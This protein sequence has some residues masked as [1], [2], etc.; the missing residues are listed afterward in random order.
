MKYVLA[1]IESAFCVVASYIAIGLALFAQGAN[2]TV[3][4][5]M[6]SRTTASAGRLD[7]SLAFQPIGGLVLFVLLTALFVTLHSRRS[8]RRT[9]VG[10]GGPLV[11]GGSPR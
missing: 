10:A 2:T 6:T 4:G 9:L 3:P 7:T 11:A 1:V 8:R 5:F